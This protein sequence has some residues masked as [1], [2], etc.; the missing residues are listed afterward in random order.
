[1]QISIQIDLKISSVSLKAQSPNGKFNTVRTLKKP[2]EFSISLFSNQ[3]ERYFMPRLSLLLF[4]VAVAAAFVPGRAQ[5][6]PTEDSVPFPSIYNQRGLDA[7]QNIRTLCN[8]IFSSSPSRFSATYNLTQNLSTAVAIVLCPRTVSTAALTGRSC[9]GAEWSSLGC[10]ASMAL[11]SA[12]ESSLPSS[13]SLNVTIAANLLPLSSTLFLIRCT[14]QSSGVDPD[15]NNE[16]RWE[17]SLLFS[18]GG[19]SLDVT[20]A[21]LAVIYPTLLGFSI[22]SC[23]FIVIAYHPVD[24]MSIRLKWIVFTFL[25]LQVPFLASYAAGWILLRTDVQN[26]DSG[27]LTVFLTEGFSLGVQIYKTTSPI[28]PLWVWYKNFPSLRIISVPVILSTLS[29]APTFMLTQ[30]F[31]T[32]A[33]FLVVPWVIVSLVFIT[34]IL[35]LLYLFLLFR[36]PSAQKPYEVLT[37]PDQPAS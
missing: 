37:H 14:D 35:N 22:I 18:N 1:M 29:L 21:P 27:M 34:L 32:V 16:V 31:A 33:G 15:A 5:F 20:Q 7:G 30:A 4:I 19:S 3:Q 28:Y 12:P 6:M 9:D 2:G 36:L 26:L 10:V 23:L 25:F 8:F 13:G 24:L 17:G 11:S